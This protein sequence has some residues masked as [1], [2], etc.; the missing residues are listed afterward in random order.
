MRWWREYTLPV[1]VCVYEEVEDNITVSIYV[2]QDGYTPLLW[3]SGYGHLSTVKE[4]LDSGA[5]IRHKD[6]VR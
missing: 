5:D 2:V 3:A 1:C 6:N 4:L